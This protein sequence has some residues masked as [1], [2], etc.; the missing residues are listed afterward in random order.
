MQ[1]FQQSAAGFVGKTDTR[2]IAEALIKEHQ[3][4]ISSRHQLLIMYGQ[5]KAQGTTVAR[6]VPA[7]RKSDSFLGRQW[8][9][10]E[11]FYELL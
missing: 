11:Q 8:S 7:K 10:F 3:E 4:R 6:V 2:E 9:K 1:T 5:G